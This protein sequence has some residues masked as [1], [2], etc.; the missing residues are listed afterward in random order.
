MAI[1]IAPWTWQ[2]SGP[3]VL[4]TGVGAIG[5]G[6]TRSGQAIPTRM[7]GVAITV[8]RQPSRVPLI[9]PSRES[10]QAGS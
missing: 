8:R 5:L 3:I 2:L 9:L 6:Q 4:R 7:S 10:K 1:K